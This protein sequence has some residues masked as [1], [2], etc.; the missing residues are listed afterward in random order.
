MR[1]TPVAV[2]LAAALLVAAPS[3]SASSDTFCVPNPGTGCTNHAALGLQAALSD[4]TN[5]TINA[6]VKIA[7]GTYTCPSGGFTVSNPNGNHIS[8]IG[9]GAGQTTLDCSPTFD[10]SSSEV[11]LITA[12]GGVTISRLRIH[13]P[14]GL[15]QY[16]DSHVG[17]WLSGGATAAHVTIDS[18]PAATGPQ[19]A[20]LLASAIRNST[21]SLPTNQNDSAIFAF[22]GSTIDRVSA[23]AGGGV[24]FG[25][26]FTVTRSTVTGPW[27]VSTDN[28]TAHV[29]D[30]LLDVSPGGSISGLFGLVAEQP[31]NG[32]STPTIIARN[33]TIVGGGGGSVGAAA[34]ANY[35]GQVAGVTL[36][37]SVI[38]G[39]ATALSRSANLGQANLTTNY[40]DYPAGTYA[41]TGSG[42]TT[43]SHVLHVNPDF[44]NPAMGA[45]ALAAGSPLI[46]AGTPG[47]LSSGEPRTDLIGLPRIL[48][49]KGTCTARRDIG[50]YEYAPGHLP[51]TAQA[52]PTTVSTGQPVKF[53]ATGCSINPRLKVHFSWA[54]GDGKTASGAVVTHEFKKP[55]TYHPTV[56]V[57]DAAGRHGHASVTVT[58]HS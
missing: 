19:G 36:T 24:I 10:N 17:M 55:G 13:I 53:T 9:A 8:V 29:Y 54:F 23:S 58:V 49:G 57:S 51:A 5:D 18:D 40:D 21:I 1:V 39:P 45:F 38:S 52:K 14:T 20:E 42:S 31:N 11:G 27:A 37:D 30:S 34:I 2:L 32:A 35:T 15:N 3:A 46:D 16:G 47:G 41:G 48:A 50:A 43:E 6:T 22:N 26:T 4:A 56:T 25:E 12:D 7:A 28:G 44:L 33:V